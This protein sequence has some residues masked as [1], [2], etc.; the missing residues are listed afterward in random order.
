LIPGGMG[1]VWVQRATCSPTSNAA[2]GF[3][4]H[5]QEI[6][7]V[8]CN[9]D[10]VEGT[11]GRTLLRRAVPGRPG[12]RRLRCAVVATGM[13]RPNP[14]HLTPQRQPAV[15]PFVALPPRFLKP[16]DQR[17]HEDGTLTGWPVAH[18]VV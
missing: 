3:Y 8:T 5:L 15:R 13:Q 17:Q 2:C 12:A 4:L 16:G 7:R 1:Q 9:F 10:V 11:Q 18:R 14:G 6:R